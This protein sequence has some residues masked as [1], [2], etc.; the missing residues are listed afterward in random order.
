MKIKQIS[1]VALMVLFVVACTKD[2]KV[3]Q[4]V[5]NQEGIEYFPF[6]STKKYIYSVDSIAYNDNDNTVDTFTFQLMQQ[7]AESFI[8]N[9]GTKVWRVKRWAKYAGT[10]N[11]IEIQNQF[12]KIY[13]NYL[14][15][16]ASNQDFV[17]A[18]FPVTLGFVWNGNLFN[19]LGRVNSK[20]N[21][22]NANISIADTSFTEALYITEQFSSDFVFETNKVSVYQ[23]NR[24]LVFFNDKNIETQT[25]DGKEKKSGYDLRQKL[26]GI[27]E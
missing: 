22:M 13:N 15:A 7:F 16:T 18:I 8:D 25:E 20:V 2:T 19:K 10:T 24:G 23:K 9:N 12:Y 21:T 17:K 14:L 1:F 26:I 4:T 3:V 5:N 11:Y 27:N 6:D